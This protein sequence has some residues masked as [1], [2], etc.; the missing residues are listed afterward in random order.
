MGRPDERAAGPRPSPPAAPDDRPAG[1]FA[2]NSPV[3]ADVVRALAEL[4]G[5]RLAG[6]AESFVP[7]FLGKA[8]MGLLERGPGELARICLD[9]ILFLDRSEPGRADAEVLNP[10]PGPEGWRQPFT[11][12]RTNVSERPFIVDTIREFISSRDLQI[13]TLVYPLMTV[14]RDAA[15]AVAGFAPPGSGDPQE[16]VVYAEV[17]RVADAAQREE[18]REETV[19]RLEDVVKSTDDFDLMVDKIG[20]IVSELGFHIRNVPERRAEFREI[21]AFLRWLRD[22]GFVFLGYREY[23]IAETEPGSGLAVMVEPGS[24]LGI[25]QDE[26]QS[27]FARPVLLADLPEGMSERATSGPLLVISKTNA[28]STVHRRARMDYIGVKK[29]G[30][31][32]SASGEHRFLGLFTSRAYAEAAQDIPILRD[33][34]ANVLERSGVAEGSHDY[35]EIITIFDSLPKEELFLASEEEIHRDV[36]T[37]LT[38]YNTEG[39]IVS[40]RRD[41]SGRGLSI[42]VVLPRARFSGGFR[43]DFERALVDRYGAVILNYHLAMSEGDQARL[44]FYVG[45]PGDR[46]AA[47]DAT[48]LEETVA[49]L[50]RSW[51]DELR[52]R[53]DAVHPPEE[54]RRLAQ[55]YEAVFPAD[56]RA[57][58]DPAVAVRDIAEI[59][60]M[61]ADGRLEAVRFFEH[62]DGGESCELK[63]YIWRHKIVL[64]DFMPVLENCGLRVIAVSPFELH[65]DDGQGGLA[66]YSFEVQADGG[67]KVD[68]EARGAVL[69]EAIL[70]VRAGDATDDAFNRLVERT[71][72]AWREADVLRAYAHYAFQLGVVPT[73]QVVR[74]ALA[75]HP[76]VGLLLFRLFEARFDPDA[77]AD[78]KDPSEAR[79][80]RAEEIKRRIAAGLA[81]VGSLA[82]DRALR[83]VQAVVDATVRTNY[84]MGVA[85]EPA[86]RSG[87]VPYVSFKFECSRLREVHASRLTYEVW[88]RSSRMEGVHL[89]GAMVAR[90]GI[91]HSDREDD[92]RREIQGLVYTQMVKNAVIVPGGSK[93]G[94]VCLRSLQSREEMAAEAKE[95]YRTLIR[96]LLDVTDNL[97]GDGVR[98]ERVV[99][100]DGFDPYLVVAADKG[101]AALSDVANALAADYGFWLDDAF[102]SGGT[103]GYDH[104]AVGIT[105]GGAW[106]SVKR[107]FRETGKDIQTEAFTVAG[108]GD[109]SGDVFGNGMLLSRE[110]RL[111]AAFDHRHVFI[112][113]DPD[114]E[115][116]FE[117]RKRI[118][119]MGRSSWDD[120]DR[121]KL[122]QGGMVVPRAIKS[123]ELTEEAAAALGL[124]AEQRALD[125]ESLIKAVLAAPV[126]LLWNGGIG[127]YV[128]AGS[129]S[130]ADAGDRSNDAVRIDVD[131]LRAAVVGEGGNLGF[132]QAA[133]VEYALTGG[134]INTDALDNSGG[135]DLSDREVNL[136]ILLNEALRAGTATGKER[137]LL[138]HRLTDQVAAQALRDNE[139]QS[140]AVSLD[141]Y[142]ARRG[143]DHFWALMGDLVRTGLLDR[144]AEGLPSWDELR[145]R[146]EANESLTRPELAVLLAYAKLHLKSALLGSDLPDDP[147]A[148]GYF[149]DYFP[150][151][152]VDLVGR[153][154]A[155]RHRLR[156]EIVASQLTNDLVDVMGAAFLTRVSRETGREADE[157]ARAWL[158]ASQLT[159]HRKTLEAICARE[160][161][162]RAGSAYRW[163]MG[164][165]QVLERTT[166]WVLA[167]CDPGESSASL[168][169]GNLGE[170]EA[171]RGRFHELVAGEDREAFLSSVGQAV[172]LGV[173]EDFARNL[174]TLRY[175]DHLLEIL[176]LARTAETSP[177]K[178]ART[179][180][181]VTEELR[182][183]WLASCIE[184]AGADGSRWERR[185]SLGLIDDIGA[186]RRHLTG[187]ALAGDD[188]LAKAF[189]F[190]GNGGRLD[191]FHRL[192]EEM[193]SEEAPPTLAGL[194]VAVQAVREAAG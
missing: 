136:K 17:E 97:D 64:S 149:F 7:I 192:L 9:T 139:Y 105:A 120:Y 126:D 111:V 176:R 164:L 150:A 103:N 128:K 101:T 134:R 66:I 52:D 49:R 90:G 137:N 190:G 177:V 72:M 122:S 161:Q 81:G 82:Y 34:L 79:H 70:A 51:A 184:K 46:L 29:L 5:E 94:F 10:D 130:H 89:R 107:H 92:F 88:V 48:E 148:A 13:K 2:A 33:K 99:C 31:G 113:P 188:T 45:G 83:A 123:V 28:E 116:S 172:R 42:M 194:S 39:V 16:S 26:T 54:A 77:F 151:A 125:G 181:W 114:P 191:R 50:T 179:Y 156:R 168:I 142:R 159:Q 19:R 86:R 185:W 8:P 87:G 129:E 189:D 93:G 22:G 167:N 166:R 104:K 135:V 138:L 36:R 47:I 106:E 14:E 155:Q 80:R 68:V 154:G 56:Y 85:G 174:F 147:A 124:P 61:R 108:I 58:N 186:I 23:A 163:V 53:L 178:A 38:R 84:Y 98:P 1:P 71:G 30:Q 74:T 158:V 165:A 140:L 127:T 76:G 67:A 73:R 115:S 41:T 100:Y 162:V 78:E 182:I 175:F 4:A 119:E 160:A 169:E 133:R 60:K 180:Y 43:R 11:A 171:L 59:E 20:D 173:D 102:A 152:A 146:R 131:D 193:E 183:P 144:E 187:A 112:D 32:G 55:R 141:E 35:K 170:I 110:I 40:L 65:E 117:E 6:L 44:H 12:V 143:V 91:R 95:Q 63:V 109:M 27:S 118:F 57:A 69:S 3:V 121:A 25:L 132:T 15:G 96:G 157:V 145:A 62:E 18:L 75:T 37:I 21:Q 24:G 153:E